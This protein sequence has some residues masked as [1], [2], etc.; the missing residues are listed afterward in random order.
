[1]NIFSD[2]PEKL[3]EELTEILIESQNIRIEKIVSD[4]H[5]SPKDFWYDQN[6]NEWIIVLKGNAKIEFEDKVVTLKEGDYLN[7]PKHKKHRVKSTSKT[8]KTI[9]L[10]VFY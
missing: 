3:P 7:I 9:W 10:A 1:M 2:I 5:N 6:E 4:G 8:E